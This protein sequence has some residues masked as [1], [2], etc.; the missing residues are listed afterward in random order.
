MKIFTR[1]AVILI[2]FI[3]VFFIATAIFDILDKQLGFY[4]KALQDTMEV[5]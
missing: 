3:T 5:G 2:T 4:A 1:L